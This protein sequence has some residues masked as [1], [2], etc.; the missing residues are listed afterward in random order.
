MSNDRVVSLETM[1]AYRNALVYGTV[2]LEMSERT[3]DAQAL[4]FFNTRWEAIDNVLTF[5]GDWGYPH[6]L[7][8]TGLTWPAL[9]AVQLRGVPPGKIFRAT[10]TSGQRLLFVGTR[11]GCAAVYMA[12]HENGSVGIHFEAINSLLSSGFMA[13]P[14]CKGLDVRG[15]RH[16]LGTDPAAPRGHVYLNIGE[17]IEA[18][19][20]HFTNPEK[21]PLY[22]L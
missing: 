14:L 7:G 10:H 11:L 18:V 8:S 2:S 6:D 15:L 4:S 3:R 9:D 22:R 17:K 21:Y 5:K 20:N 19:Y 1:E 13:L 12:T 16:I